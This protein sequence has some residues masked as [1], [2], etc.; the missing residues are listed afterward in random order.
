MAQNV[1]TTKRTRI[2]E[3]VFALYIL[4]TSVLLGI[5]GDFRNIFPNIDL[6]LELVFWSAFFFAPL[7]LGITVLLGT[8]VNDTS[9]SSF[10]IG[11]IA[12]VTL[13]VVSFC[14][15]WFVNPPAG[16]GLV[17]A[18]LISYAF[19]VAL[20]LIIGLKYTIRRV[21]PSE[22]TSEPVTRE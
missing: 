7:A 18:H 16:D 10:V 4:G 8:L 1:I 15:Y 17:V 2:G 14:I 12:G 9:I 11:V 19:G 21:F 13:F 20:S 6:F 22:A 5:F 3:L